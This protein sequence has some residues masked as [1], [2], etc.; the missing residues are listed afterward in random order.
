M[1]FR[2]S[3][4]LKTCTL[5]T[6]IITTYIYVFT[7]YNDFFRQEETIK[8]MK[9]HKRIMHDLIKKKLIIQS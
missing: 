3:F 4:T 8:V 7:N 2:S 5:L 1:F 9:L 6:T